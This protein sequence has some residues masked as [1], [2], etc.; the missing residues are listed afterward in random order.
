[1]TG[2]IQPPLKPR[3]AVAICPVLALWTAMDSIFSPTH[4]VV[5]TGTSL[6]VQLLAA[7]V[8]LVVM[9]VI[10]GAGIVGVTKY[11]RL[12]DRSLRAHRVDF[13]A[14]GLLITIALCLFALHL[15]EIGIFALFYRAVGALGDLEAA[16][17][18]SISAYSTL[19]QPDL[20]FPAQWRILGAIE[21]LVGFLLI[22]WSTAIFYA[23]INKLLREKAGPGTNSPDL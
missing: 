13:K 14:F 8:L 15:L 3:I 10:H 1:M 12:E 9:V 7:L 17:Y 16:L 4:P 21:G 23:D 22:G 2:L 19:G 20:E 18:F 6:G 11:L 5:V